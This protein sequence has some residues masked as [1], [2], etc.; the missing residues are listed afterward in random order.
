VPFF[1]KPRR[2]IYYLEAQVVGIAID[3]FF[4]YTKNIPHFLRSSVRGFFALPIFIASM[5]LSVLPAW[6]GDDRTTRDPSI[7]LEDKSCYDLNRAYERLNNSGRMTSNIYE[8]YPNGNT[9]LFLQARVID[10]R[11]FEKI[12]EGPWKGYPRLPI[13]TTIDAL[14]GLPVL[15]ACQ[16]QGVETVIGEP[17]LR[18]AADWRRNGWEASLD[19]WVS[20][21]SGKIVKTVSH[22]RASNN[23]LR[24]Q[25]RSRAAKPRAMIGMGQLMTMGAELVMP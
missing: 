22:Y 14:T 3:D 8:L 19:A 13:H 1:S 15:T 21:A 6:P 25:P 17:A 7:G 24:A 18:Y 23:G 9:R 5:T 20:S 2:S 10:R 11:F 12:E 16:Y 4:L